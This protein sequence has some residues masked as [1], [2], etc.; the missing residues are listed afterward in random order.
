MPK[1]IEDLSGQT[2]GKWQVISLAPKLN[3]NIR[4]HCR[5]ECGT[6]REVLSKNLKSG[7]SSS[8]GCVPSKNP[9][10]TDLTGKKF[11]NWSVLKLES[12][13]DGTNYYACKCT[14]GNEGI[15]RSTDLKTNRSKSCGC[16]SKYSHD[17]RLATANH[18]FFHYNDGDL[19]FQE[20]F[21]LT[22][23][24]CHYCDSSFTNRSNRY[25]W[26]GSQR[27]KDF[28]ISSAT[29]LY[30]GLD[31]IDS[32]LPHNKNNVVSCCPDCNYAKNDMSL[33]KFKQWISKVYNFYVKPE[34]LT[35]SQI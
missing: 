7:I 18:I 25:E 17:P 14:C 28:N 24:P 34:E 35:N 10:F 2:F 29:F 5:C 1:R 33:D 9:Q 20:F 21:D 4:Y 6:E 8:C 26:I 31:R 23:K 22:Q 11:N 15:V 13:R 27:R 12:N 32:A 19:T 3:F 16:L 30:N